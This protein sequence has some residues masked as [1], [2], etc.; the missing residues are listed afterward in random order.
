[1]EKSYYRNLLK[2]AKESN[3]SP[4]RLLCAVSADSHDLELTDD[5]F[6]RISGFIYEWCMDDLESAVVGK[7]NERI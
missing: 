5:E 3:I 1:M 7:T 4:W 6:D 2:I